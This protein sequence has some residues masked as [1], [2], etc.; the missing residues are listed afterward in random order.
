MRRV[1]LRHY[2]SGYILFFFAHVLFWI[3]NWPAYSVIYSPFFFSKFGPR[4]KI[5]TV[6][7]ITRLRHEFLETLARPKKCTFPQSSV[8]IN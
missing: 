5:G 7:N 2:A 6:E 4:S 1:A 8:K 3:L